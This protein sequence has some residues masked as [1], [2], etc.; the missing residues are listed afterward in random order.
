[1]DSKDHTS[2]SVPA[3]RK[4]Y[5]KPRLIPYGHVKDIVQGGGAKNNDGGGAG[6][7]TKP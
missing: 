3:G 5:T 4:P 7:N 6:P 2:S 1:M